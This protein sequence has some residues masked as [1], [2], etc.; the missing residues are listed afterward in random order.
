LIA[1][2]EPDNVASI[3]VAENTGMEYEADVMLEGYIYPDRVYSITK[4][5][6]G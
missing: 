1:I 6:Y 2:I 3:H 5:D 4:V